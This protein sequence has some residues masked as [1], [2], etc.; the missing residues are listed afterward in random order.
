M[1]FEDQLHDAI[2]E[3]DVKGVKRILQ[4]ADLLNRSI[5]VHGTPL[6]IASRHNQLHI[7]KFLIQSG[8]EVNGTVS[9]ESGGK[10]PL[11]VAIR[12]IHVDMAKLLIDS[13]ADV[14]LCDLMVDETPLM[15]A[16]GMGLANVVGWLLGSGGDPNKT[17]ADGLSAVHLAARAGNTEVMRLLLDAGAKA[18]LC[19]KEGIG[20]QALHIAAMKGHRHIVHQLLQPKAHPVSLSWWDRVKSKVFSSAASESQAPLHPL[21]DINAVTLRGG[22]TPL[23][24]AVR[25]DMLGSHVGLVRDLVDAGININKKNADDESA[26]YMACSNGKKDV[27]TILL[28]A[29]ADVNIGKRLVG[30]KIRSKSMYQFTP[31]HVAVVA[32]DL[33]LVKQLM[34]YGADLNQRGY[35]NRTTSLVVAM[36][37][38]FVPIAKYMILEGIEKGLKFYDVDDEGASLLHFVSLSRDGEELAELLIGKGHA[39]NVKDNKDDYPIHRAVIYSNID[40]IEVLLQHGSV[41]NQVSLSKHS[42][43]SIAVSLEYSDIVS[44]LLSYGAAINIFCRMN[45]LRLRTQITV[46]PLFMAI[47]SSND[48]L[49]RL[50]VNSDAH[51]RNEAYFYEGFCDTFSPYP[52][53]FFE[54]S[55]ELGKEFADW[56]LEKAHNPQSLMSLCRASIRNRMQYVNVCVQQLDYVALPAKIRDYIIMRNTGENFIKNSRRFMT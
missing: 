32:N 25:F 44:L 30:H 33:D 21:V 23:H 16:T 45:D 52:S 29:G 1:I 8:A 12:N 35:W 10:T 2:A 19:T 11:L 51:F 38:S 24:L 5:G 20:Y 15:Q 40:V 22:E 7:A 42:P 46:T 13:G 37:M 49:I 41:V 43:L 54:L 53:R 56:L 18:Y 31:L 27:V 6:C 34:D 47:N 55:D 9:Y 26:L 28:K 36:T 48:E 4:S 39:V 50:V 3:G 14:N 17:A